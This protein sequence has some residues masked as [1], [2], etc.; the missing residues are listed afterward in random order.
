M[1]R[2]LLGLV[3]G[4][5][6]VLWSCQPSLGEECVVFAQD[7][8]T[9]HDPGGAVFRVLVTFPSLDG[10]VGRELHFARLLLPHLDVSEG[11]V[12]EAYP[13]TSPWDPETVT[14]DSP[15]VKPG[16]DFERRIHGSYRIHVSRDPEQPVWLD[17]TDYVYG[18]T[19]HARRNYGLLIKP[20]DVLGTGYNADLADQFVS[21]ALPDSIRIVAHV[22]DARQ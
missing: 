6:L 11:I 16:G 19:A 18:I 4:G 14:W 15:W 13:V 7:V 20:P 2:D 12:L 3:V 21:R 1:N 8:V 22:G 17:V 9:M 10:L 5:L